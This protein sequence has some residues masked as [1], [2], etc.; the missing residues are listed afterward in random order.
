MSAHFVGAES[1]GAQSGLIVVAA[2]V[3]ERAGRF[4]VTR[5]LKDTHLSGYWEFPGGKSEP[6]ETI[7]ACLARELR[8]ELGVA[9]EIGA[10]ILVVEHA[11]AT[12]TVRLHFKSCTLRDEPAPLL[13]QEMQWITR[14]DMRVL[15]CPDADRDLIDLLTAG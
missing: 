15:D 7:D 14:D 13:G 12:R 1:P 6:G 10:E 11:Y 9:V 2:A 4:L 8:E 5:R 3:I